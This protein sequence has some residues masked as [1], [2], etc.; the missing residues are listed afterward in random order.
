MS[1]DKKPEE[2]QPE[3]QSPVENLAAALAA[4]P[5]APTVQV[6]EGWKQQFGEVMA[7]GFTDDELFVWRPITRREY[8]ALQK[9]MATPKEGQEPLNGFDFEDRVVKTCL[10]WSSVQN[11]DSKGGTIPTLSE[12]IMQNSNFTS[13]QLAGMLVVKL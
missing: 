11:L 13:P 12:Q 1:E 8:V 5:G 2:N 9:E 4:Y 7:S 10:L 3:E 6:I